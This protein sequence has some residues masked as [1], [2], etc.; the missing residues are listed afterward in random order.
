MQRIPQTVDGYPYQEQLNGNGIYNNDVYLKSKHTCSDFSQ[1]KTNENYSL[2]V[3]R[4][5]IEWLY[6]KIKQ[7]RERK[8][9]FREYA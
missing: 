2:A 4:E 9:Y 5:S 8:A 3:A 7:L 6:A 1:R